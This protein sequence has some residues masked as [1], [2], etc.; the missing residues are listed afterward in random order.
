VWIEADNP[1]LGIDSRHFGPIP[2]EWLRGKLVARLW[3]LWR[4]SEVP[5]SRSWNI[6]PHPIPLDPETLSEYNVHR[7][8]NKT[9]DRGQVMPPVQHD[10]AR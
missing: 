6:R 8:V 1:A 7:L 9:R 4:S 3:P 2:V 5:S 10:P